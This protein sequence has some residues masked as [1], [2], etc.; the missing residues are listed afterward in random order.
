MSAYLERLQPLVIDIFSACTSISTCLTKLNF[1]YELST[2]IYYI[3][4]TCIA[5]PVARS[6]SRRMRAKEGSVAVAASCACAFVALVACVA[7]VGGK[8][9]FMALLR[10]SPY[11][12]VPEA[13]RQQRPHNLR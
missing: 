12:P 8:I 6:S 3:T 7:V 11:F 13:V 10:S 9:V 2:I 5:G 1:I 4:I